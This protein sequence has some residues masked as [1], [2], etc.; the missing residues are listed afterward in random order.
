MVVEGLVGASALVLGGTPCGRERS[1]RAR[2]RATRSYLQR[3][4]LHG[5]TNEGADVGRRK[6]AKDGAKYR[7]QKHAAD[8]ALL[9][10]SRRSSCIVLYILARLL[11]FPTP[12]RSLGAK[13]SFDYL[14]QDPY[15]LPTKEG[16]HQ[17][18]WMHDDFS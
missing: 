14:G 15:Q 16:R 1:R 8:Q 10:S 3:P 18:R 13:I 6:G 9:A 12:L 11:C 5:A 4:L 7:A 2:A 17:E